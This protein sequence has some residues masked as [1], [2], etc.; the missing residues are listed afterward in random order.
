MNVDDALRLEFHIQVLTP[1][2]L[3]DESGLEHNLGLAVKEDQT[4]NRAQLEAKMALQREGRSFT[5]AFTI[6]NPSIM[7]L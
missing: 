2:C 1:H 5:I 3:G 6:T 7:T 4:N